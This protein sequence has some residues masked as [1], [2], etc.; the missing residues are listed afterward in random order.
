MHWIK[1][2]IW[3]LGEQAHL[4]DGQSVWD[5]RLSPS[6]CKVMLI[7]LMKEMAEKQKERLELTF[8]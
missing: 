4:R 7:V 5:D 2:I 6:A 8:K 3:F 1:K